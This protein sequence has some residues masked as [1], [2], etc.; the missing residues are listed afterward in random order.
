MNWQTR[1]WFWL[2]GILVMIIVG[3]IAYILSD[4]EFAVDLLTFAGTLTS[5]FLSVIAIFI[6]LT[7]SK[8]SKDLHSQSKHILGRIDEKIE[9]I[10]DRVKEI[11][12]EQVNQNIK[13]LET[14]V[15]NAVVKVLKSNPNYRVG[16]EDN[17]EVE[18]A[19]SKEVGNK[20]KACEN[21]INH[22]FKNSSR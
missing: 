20:F 19:I 10:D 14:D 4:I 9:G 2:T 21:R 18:Q 11:Q 17:K 7:F 13:D 12:Q 6:T 8:D 15:I 3:V 16:E 5:L 22:I 1:D